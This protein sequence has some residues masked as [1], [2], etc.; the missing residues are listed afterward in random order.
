MRGIFTGFLLV[1]LS[2]PVVAYAAPNESTD[3]VVITFK[4]GHQQTFSVGDIARIEFKSPAAKTAA[5]HIDASGRH[6]FVGKWIVGDGSGKTY[7]FTLAENGDATNNV[8][9]GGHGSWTYID[10]EARITWDNGWHDAIRKVGSKY[11]K[12]AHAPGTSFDSPPTNTG[13]AQRTNP[14]PI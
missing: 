10:G 8:D 9:S 14:E 12:F 2:L 7:Q 13:D 3:S 4:D 5:T 6:R 1:L 11:Q